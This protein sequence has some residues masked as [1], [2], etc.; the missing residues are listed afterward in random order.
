MNPFLQVGGWPGLSHLECSW[1]RRRGRSVWCICTSGKQLSQ[2]RSVWNKGGLCLSS[3]FSEYL[4]IYEKIDNYLALGWWSFSSENHPKSVIHTVLICSS[5]TTASTGETAFL[6]MLNRLVIKAY[7]WKLSSD[8]CSIL[9]LH[10][11]EFGS[12]ISRYFS[13]LVIEHFGLPH[14]FRFP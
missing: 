9:Y 8:L 13:T 1:N 7:S 11:P 2:Q 4:I 14:S 5:I 12:F 3:C 10:D 6:Q